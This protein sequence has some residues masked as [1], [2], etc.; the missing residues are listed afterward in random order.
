MNE[1]MIRWYVSF[2]KQQDVGEVT[3]V[4]KKNKMDWE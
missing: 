4:P 3:S 1:L 2:R